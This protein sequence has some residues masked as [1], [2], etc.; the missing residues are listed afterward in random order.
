METYKRI[1]FVLFALIL[2]GCDSVPIPDRDDTPPVVGCTIYV[3]GEEIVLTSGG[4]D[5]SRVINPDENISIIAMAKDEDGGV[6]RACI[7][8]AAKIRC[9]DGQHAQVKDLLTQPICSAN[10]KEPGEK[11]KTKRV[12]MQAIDMADYVGDCQPGFWSTNVT[13]TVQAT[14]RNYHNGTD[15]TATFKFEVKKSVPNVTIERPVID[16]RFVKNESVIF[17]AKI[18][19]P[20]TVDGS[21]LKWFSDKEGELGHGLEITV[22]GLYVGNHEI[23][24]VG[25]DQYERVPIRVFNNLLELYKAAPSEAEINR[26]R[27]EFSIEWVDGEENDEKW[28]NYDTFEF[29][30]NSPDPSKIVGIAK[31]DICRHQLFSEPL[32]FANGKSLYD[33]IRTNVKK[34]YVRLDCRP[35]MGGAD[36]IS[37]ARGFSVWHKGRCKAPYPDLKL[38]SYPPYGT[39]HEGRH[40]EEDD[41]GHIWCISWHDMLNNLFSVDMEFQSELN[42]GYLSQ[43]LRELFNDNGHWLPEKV[44]VEVAKESSE[45]RL[46]DTETNYPLY[47]IL[48]EGQM[49]NIY[50]FAQ[51]DPMLEN[52][53]GHA[54]AALYLMLVYK[55]GIS[56]PLDIKDKCKQIAEMLL[57]ERF[58]SRPTHSNPKVQAIINEL[59]N[60]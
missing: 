42:D 53:S 6:K 57:L 48:K 40:C 59:L 2:I 52:G 46:F 36:G 13:G 18:Y 32:P 11:G 31:L 51:C 34:I 35:S 30:Q 16:E 15:E 1:L 24:V 23:K 49:L 17:K 39:V 44:D 10:D 60:N 56:D 26:V 45:W 33:H 9:T 20:N 55:Y 22:N 38:K 8:Y 58:A 27:D 28:A 5:V 12:V 29:D 41:P 50:Y 4:S 7:E 25:Y 47:A 19:A 3:G 43:E 21:E 37:L 54:Q 14:A